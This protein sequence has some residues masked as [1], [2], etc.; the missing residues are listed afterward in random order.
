MIID[1]QKASSQTTE[2][3]YQQPIILSIYSKYFD[4][5]CFIKTVILFFSFFVTALYVLYKQQHIEHTLTNEIFF[6]LDH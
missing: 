4:L 6:T 5:S 3:I 2:N 1:R